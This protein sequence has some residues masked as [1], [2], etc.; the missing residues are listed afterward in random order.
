MKRLRTRAASTK[1]EKLRLTLQWILRKKRGSGQMLERVMA[2]V[3]CVS[4]VRRPLLSAFAV[5]YKFQRACYHEPTFLWAS[6]RSE[7]QHLLGATPL[8]E[9]DWS[10]PWSGTVMAT[11]ACEGRYGVVSGE[12]APSLA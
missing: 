4:L 11:D 9:S 1:Y 8:L 12:F 2:H 6:G 10:L 5:V 3:T 7:L